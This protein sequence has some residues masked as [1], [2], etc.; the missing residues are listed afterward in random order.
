[1]CPGLLCD[2]LGSFW[3]S[4]YFLLQGDKTALMWASIKGH[5][6]C[7]KTLLLG[8]ADPNIQDGVSSTKAGRCLLLMC[9]LVVCVTGD[10]DK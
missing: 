2:G 3:Y 1:M 5:T 8:G 6:K 9:V 10:S 4:I 7:V